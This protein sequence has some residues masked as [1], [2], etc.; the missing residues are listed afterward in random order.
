MENAKAWFHVA[1]EQFISTINPKTSLSKTSLITTQTAQCCAVRATTLT[2]SI[3]A[4]ELSLR[5]WCLHNKFVSEIRQASLTAKN[6]KSLKWRFFLSNSCSLNQIA[7]SDNNPNYLNKIKKSYDS[8]GKESKTRSCP[9]NARNVLPEST[10]R[11]FSSLTTE[12][13]IH[14]P[15]KK[16][17]TNDS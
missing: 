11:H 5:L 2:V 8:K 12:V 3:W 9:V 15:R 7:K 17:L 1:H 14:G 16:W 10:K 4:N 13:L 6:K